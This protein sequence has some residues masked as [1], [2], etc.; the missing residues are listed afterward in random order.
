TTAAVPA[1]PRRMLPPGFASSLLLL[2]LLVPPL[3]ARVT[4]VE[5]SSR[6]D[7]WNGR[8]LGDAG[9]YERIIGR[10]YFSLPVANPHNLRIVDLSNAVTL[11]NCE[12]EASSDLIA[13]RS[14]A[15]K[16]AE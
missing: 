5:I 12:D 4:R 2:A 8:A 10:V 16:R 1:L 13:V 15:A 3:D 6:T 9:T 11:M 7:V 14:N